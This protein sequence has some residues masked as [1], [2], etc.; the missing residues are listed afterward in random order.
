MAEANS[1][2]DTIICRKPNTDKAQALEGARA[3][4]VAIGKIDGICKRDNKYWE[5]SAEQA[6]DSNAASVQSS[7]DAI[8]QAIGN[9]PPSQRGFV[10]AMAEYID[11][12]CRFGQPALEKW[13]PHAAM[14]QAEAKQ[15]RARTIADM[16]G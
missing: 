1:T 4:L 12:C 11:F 8:M 15:R 10:M 6:F 16:M 7:V 9:L 3:A 13:K 2:R 5:E 14:T